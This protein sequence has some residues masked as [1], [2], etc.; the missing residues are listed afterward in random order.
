MSFRHLYTF[1]NKVKIV[2][3]YESHVCAYLYV[4]NSDVHSLS[5]TTFSAWV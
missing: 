5:A 2:F 3:E 1:D 4:S